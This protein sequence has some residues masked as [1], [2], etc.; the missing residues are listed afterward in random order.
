[1]ESDALI[2]PQIKR[3]PRFAGLGLKTRRGWFDGLGLKTIGIGFDW[4]GP[5]NRG[6]TNWRTHGGISELAS[7]QSRVKKARGLLDR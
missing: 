4:F 6:L 5:Q 1:M 3:L 2:W 7:R